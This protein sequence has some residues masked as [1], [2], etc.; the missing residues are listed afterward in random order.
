MS[1]L[2]ATYYAVADIVQALQPRST[3]RLSSTFTVTR[4]NAYWRVETPHGNRR[5]TTV[6]EVPVLAGGLWPCTK[7]G[8]DLKPEAFNFTNRSGHQYRRSYCR[9][10]EAFKHASWF[11]RK[12]KH[13]EFRDDRAV[14]AR[15][16]RH[17]NRE[18]Y[19]EKVRADRKLKAWR[20]VLGVA[21]WL[22]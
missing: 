13:K 6:R 10:C 5:V 1:T 9:R 12:W 15:H 18:R 7:C 4:T 16:W 20:R 2:A 19:L 14:K 17:E 11:Q 21:S 22:R 8:R 3:L